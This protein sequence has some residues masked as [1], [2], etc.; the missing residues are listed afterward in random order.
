[1]ASMSDEDGNGSFWSIG[2]SLKRP[3]KKRSK[4]T[5]DV[6]K[7]P[8]ARSKCTILI[9]LITK[10]LRI[11]IMVTGRGEI[12]KWLITRPIFVDF[13]HMNSDTAKYSPFYE[14]NTCFSAMCDFK[15]SLV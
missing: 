7:S 10:S 6:R 1:M 15:F 5:S 12:V 4:S 14:V 13:W 8:S 11:P 9:S 2:R 3:S